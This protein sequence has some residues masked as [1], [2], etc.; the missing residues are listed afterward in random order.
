MISV[1]QSD[2]R[3]A[4]AL[5]LVC[6]ESIS[7]NSIASLSQGVLVLDRDK[8]G[9]QLKHLNLVFNFKGIKIS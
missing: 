9:E 6:V 5:M 1:N 4:G 2:G 7:F 8:V 3:E